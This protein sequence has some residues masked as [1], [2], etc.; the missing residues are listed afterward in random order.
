MW[1]CNIIDEV[2]PRSSKY[3]LSPVFHL[4]E[5]S[6]KMKYRNTQDGSLWPYAAHIVMSLY[7]AKGIKRLC[8]QTTT[9]RIDYTQEWV[10][11]L[12]SPRVCGYPEAKPRD[13]CKQV[14]YGA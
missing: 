7:L 8:D 13:K 12:C 5:F 1:A 3:I 4:H 10:M 14:G 6:Q 2:V 11:R 9:Y